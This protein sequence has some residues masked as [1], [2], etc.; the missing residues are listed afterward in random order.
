MFHRIKG[1][2]LTSI[3]SNLLTL[4]NYLKVF[5][6][7]VEF[8][9]LLFSQIELII[10]N[11]RQ[12]PQQNVDVKTCSTKLNIIYLLGYILNTKKS[13]YLSS[14]NQNKIFHVGIIF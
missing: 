10:I 5:L 13:L 9:Y 6:S 4:N 3:F 11:M 2:N 8:V 7:L 12:F 1:V 14:N